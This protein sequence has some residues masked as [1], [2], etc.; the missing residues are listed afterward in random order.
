MVLK[1]PHWKSA[2]SLD[3]NSSLAEGM[4]MGKKLI[5]QRLII[6]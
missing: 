4:K 5:L 3:D 6:D 2:P 1:K